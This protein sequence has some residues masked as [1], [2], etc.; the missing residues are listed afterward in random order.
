MINTSKKHGFV[1]TPHSVVSFLTT[2]AVRRHTD[3]VLDLGSGEGVFL[4]EAF[5]RLVHLG[6]EEYEAT[7]Q[8]IG[9]EIAKERY[10]IASTVLRKHLGRVP[11]QFYLSD[12]F[13]THFTLPQVDAV[14]GNPP[15]VRRSNLEGLDAIRRRVVESSA[16]C[17]NLPALTDLYAYFILFAVSLMKPGARL[18]LVLPTSWLDVDYGVPVKQTLLSQFKLTA[19]ILLEG[20]VFDNVLVRPVLLLAEKSC[21]SDGHQTAFVRIRRSLPDP[22][23][24]DCLFT[25]PQQ[26]D[27][28]V[29]LVKQNS[30]DPSRPWSTLLKTPHAYQMIAQRSDF[31]TLGS[32]AETRIGIQ[33]LAGS[34][35]I[36]NEEMRQKL[37]IPHCYLR[38]IVL[39]PRE[40]KRGVIEHSDEVSSRVLFVDLP[41]SEIS[42]ENTRRYIQL[43]ETTEV[44]IRGKNI[45][46]F[47]YQNV[48]RIQQARRRPWYNLK[49]EIVRRGCYPLLLP[50]RIYKNYVV[51]WN[52]ANV[53][54]NENF[55]EVKPKESSYTLP[56][57]AVLN[58]SC[59][60]LMARSHAQLY[61]GGIYNLNPA[62]VKQLP[63][64]DL[65]KLSQESLDRLSQMALR[66]LYE[67][68]TDNK[69][70]LD[71]LVMY[72]VLQL[73][74]SEVTSIREAITELKHI[75]L[76]VKSDA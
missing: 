3:T 5:H 71:K 10:D 36:I 46:V 39:S 26:H 34:F 72:E 12:F 33:T 30:L 56:L 57:S 41:L 7:E 2:W 40:T 28:E 17:P 48:P 27:A 11:S 35:F 49:T 20:R 70:L 8:L 9:V 6:R 50:R 42:D 13:A 45:T 24:P 15:Y 53:V 64:L 75:S 54:T 43:A 51:V 37:A 76:R 29:V 21:T 55:I 58:S 59:F 61:G 14:I 19:L 18:A 1:A 16:L 52:R 23:Q 73:A 38:P 25:Y 4:V 74:D 44:R 47:G 32:L 31:T 68:S 66:F 60:E 62:D 22:C 63:V 69:E 67:P 65:R